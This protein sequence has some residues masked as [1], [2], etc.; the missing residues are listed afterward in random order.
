MPIALRLFLTF[1]S[2][3]PCACGSQ[4]GLEL[5]HANVCRTLGMTVLAG[6]PAIVLE[7]CERGSVADLVL[8]EGS[9]V[10]QTQTLVRLVVECARGVS[11][12]HEQGVHHRDL[13]PDNVLL[14]SAL[15]AK[16]GDFG[17][18][19]RYGME[20]TQSHTQQGTIRYL[21]P[22]VVFG[23][24]TKKAD[25]YSFAMLTYAILHREQPFAQ[26]SSVAVLHL[27]A[28][29]HRRPQIQLNAS[30]QP[31]A[32]HIQACWHPEIM[33]RPSM[34]EVLVRLEQTAAAG[35]PTW[36]TP[37]PLPTSEDV[38]EA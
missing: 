5:H 21:A 27:V 4:L 34:G 8:Q 17:L 35:W 1:D 13:K 38:T 28:L 36:A 24:Y 32:A 14:D 12:L 2:A 3:S 19:S 25:V 26:F 9:P 23:A 16:I 6:R 22:E 15:H 18:S 29:Q 7:L 31:F 33:E 20:H 30:L 11:Y 10:P 37:L